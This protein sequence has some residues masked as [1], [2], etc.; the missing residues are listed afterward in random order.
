MIN[1]SSFFSS[2]KQEKWP[3]NTFGVKSYLETIV[4]IPFFTHLITVITI[5]IQNSW[6]LVCISTAYDYCLSYASNSFKRKTRYTK[7]GINRQVHVK[8]D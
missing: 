1:F 8:N 2:T 5:I 3:V 6:I 7:E 4:F